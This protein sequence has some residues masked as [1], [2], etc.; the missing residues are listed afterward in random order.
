[1]IYYILKCE[2]YYMLLFLYKSY[3]SLTLYLNIFIY[4]MCCA[5]DYIT[6]MLYCYIRLD[7]IRYVISKRTKKMKENL[8]IYGW[9]ALMYLKNGL[10]FAFHNSRGSY[11][12]K[13]GNL[14]KYG[15]KSHPYTMNKHILS[16]KFS[17]LWLVS[18]W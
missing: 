14:Y 13:Y 10:Q 1:M 7:C 9:I 5:T 6:N 8:P 12:E 3:I 16:Y 15:I 4:K 18:H 17:G 2:K 11:V